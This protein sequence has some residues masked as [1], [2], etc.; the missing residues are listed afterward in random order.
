MLTASEPPADV[1]PFLFPRACL[2]DHQL[3]AACV[4]GMPVFASLP[5][6][7][8]LIDID[9]HD[10]RA[11]LE[12]RRVFERLC[13][14]CAAVRLDMIAVDAPLGRRAFTRAR[15][16][17]T[18]LFVNDVDVWQRSGARTGNVILCS[19]RRLISMPRGR[20]PD[21][22]THARCRTHGRRTILSN[23][24]AKSAI[25]WRELAHEIKTRCGGITGGAQLSQHET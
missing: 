19:L 2:P 17:G 13:N 24:P 23:P 9:D 16:N 11:E 8:I 6:P 12:G 3:E 22:V 18:P 14:P 25:A 5:V 10:R 4:A 1:T 7:A 15:E 21:D 20:D